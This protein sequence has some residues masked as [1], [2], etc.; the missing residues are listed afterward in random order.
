VRAGRR[1]RAVPAALISLLVLFPVLAHAATVRG[2]V[3]DAQT[4]APLVAVN[5]SLQGAK[6]GALTDE[7]GSRCRTSTTSPRRVPRAGRSA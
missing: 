5:I 4:R 7:L 3:L 1:T 6:R 2:R